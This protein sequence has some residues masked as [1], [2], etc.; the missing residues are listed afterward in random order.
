[1]TKQ[2]KLTILNTTEMCEGLWT[3]TEGESM[4]VIDYILIDKDSVESV[5]SMTVDE[6]KEFSPAGYV[7]NKMTHSDHNVLL[8]SLDWI[9]MEK[10]QQKDE[11]REIT[12]SKGMENIRREMQEE[13][14]SEMLQEEGNVTKIYKG[15]KDKV[16]EIWK[17]NTT[18]VKKKN[19]RGST[20]I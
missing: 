18:R 11:S 8:A 2:E 13:R 9:I 19:P 6:S 5:K 17:G 16:N 3:R 14:V 4:S 15:W 10:K 20:G 12:T 7:D 1:M